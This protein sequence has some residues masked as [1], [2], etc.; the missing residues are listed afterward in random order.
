[1]KRTRARRRITSLGYVG[2]GIYRTLS[3]LKVPT[4]LMAILLAGFSIFLLGGGVYD[5]IS[6]P[7][8]IIPM[9]GRIITVYPYY[10]HEQTLT[11]SIGVMILYTIGMIGLILLYESTKYVRN[12]RQASI[13]ILIGITLIALVFISMEVI[14][15]LKLNPG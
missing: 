9:R 4:L 14:L 13:L 3:R 6:N 1:M 8:S 15:H 10:I 7:I 11:A 2:R 12:P 5:I